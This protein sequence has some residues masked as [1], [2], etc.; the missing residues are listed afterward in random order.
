M[1]ISLIVAIGLAVLFILVRLRQHPV[2]GLLSK[3]SASLG[4][5]A[6]GVVAFLVASPDKT[7]I[8]MLFGAVLGLVGDMVLDLKYTHRK[9]YDQYLISGMG[10][11]LLGHVV[12]FIGLT[13]YAKTLEAQLFWPILIS[14]IAAPIL[15]LIIIGGGKLL[16]LQF[17]RFFV[18]CLGYAFVLGFLAVYAFMLFLQMPVYLPFFIG[19]VLFMASDSLLSVQYFA[20]K[21]DNTTLTII[22]HALYYAAQISLMLGLFFA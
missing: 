19:L 3:T 13:L 22:T 5:V 1:I 4:F 14:A 21:D 2:F 10:A 16:G 18:P 6:M 8:L 7:L 17:G 9:Y 15:A 12:Y 11:F 20:G